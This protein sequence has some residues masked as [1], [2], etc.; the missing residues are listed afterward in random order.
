MNYSTRYKGNMVFLPKIPLTLAL[1]HKG[2]GDYI[3]ISPP[4]MGGDGE[5]V[6]IFMSLCADE[7]A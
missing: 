7:S 6:R 5:G 1:S 4:S 2:R 3:L